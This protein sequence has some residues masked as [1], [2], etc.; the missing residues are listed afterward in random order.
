MKADNK[1]KRY[2]DYNTYLRDLFGERVQKIP[3]DAG[4]GC[5]NR[6]GTIGQGGC[7]YCDG[8]GSGTGALVDGG[9]SIEE[10]VQRGRA[11]ASARYG[12]SLFIAYFQSFTNTYAPVETLRSLYRRALSAPGMVGLSVGTR[13]D[14]AGKEVLDLLADFGQK[15]VVWVEYGLQSS[16]DSTLAV[17]NRGHDA[18]CFEDAVQR[19]AARGLNV[20]AH[21]ILGLPGETP[22][23]MAET[24]LYLARLPVSGV[25]IHLLYVVADS[26]MGALYRQGRYRCL[27]R[28]EYVDLVVAFLE[29]L[30]WRIVVQRLTGDPPRDLR[31]L[32]PD[33]A[34]DKTETL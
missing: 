31:V 3:L 4:L 15:Y 2:R 32:G 14:C 7:I 29:R 21:V 5:P 8:R 33:W 6:D 24:A 11:F 16:H 10:Q 19:T 17:I 30:P 27:D 22:E 20:C 28:R 23:M 13:P 34:Y 26:P 18:A 9:L 25:K 12:A 1:G